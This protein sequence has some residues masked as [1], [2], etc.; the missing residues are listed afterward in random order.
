MK[1]FRQFST[2]L[3]A[4]AAYLFFATAYAKAPV[5]TF[6]PSVTNPPTASVSSSGTVDV[7]YTV[8]NHSLKAHNL[9]I[10]PTKGLRQVDPCQV[11]PVGTMG[12]SCTLTLRVD[13]SAL[14]PAGLK[15]GP[16]L[17]QANTDGSP[18]HNQCYQPSKGH[19]LSISVQQTLSVSVSNLALAAAGSPRI[20]T[21]TNLGAA[22]ALNVNYSASPALPSGTSVSPSS[23]GTMAPLSTCVLTIT[24]GPTPSANPGDLSPLPINLAISGSNTNTVTPQINILTYGSV[25]QGGYLFAIDDTPPQAASIG[26]KV[27]ALQNQATQLVDGVVWS[28]NGVGSQSANVSNDIIPGIGCELSDC[29]VPSPSY[30]AALAAYNSTYDNEAT[31]PFPSSSAFQECEGGTDGA[32]NTANI[33]TFYES[34][35]TNFGVGSSPYILASGPTDSDFYAAGLCTQTISGYD[36]WYLPA[37]CEMGSV[38]QPGTPCSSSTEN[39]A[40]KLTDLIGNQSPA[41]PCLYQSTYPATVCLAGDYW[42]STE[43]ALL[44]F[45]SDLATYQ[46]FSSLVNS[47][48]GGQKSLELGV[49]C[50]RVITP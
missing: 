28:S 45:A 12:S 10:K 22:N 27:L 50:A 18:N 23:C 25:Y 47:H 46:F 4:L 38:G 37:L 35:K 30:A 41:A 20:L 13:G 31:F 15:G 39:I 33:L 43:F 26:G 32:C 17:C 48:T 6:V 14:G 3:V 1:Y 19:S 21:V 49:R 29:V 9:V 5:W 40:D 8:N 24:P 7:I 44:P 11:G 34:V 16:V 36:D 42:S 2:C